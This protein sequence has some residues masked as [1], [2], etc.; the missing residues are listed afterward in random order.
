M[1]A[2]VVLVAPCKAGSAAG[3]G[4]AQPPAH[5]SPAMSPQLAQEWGF[6][7]PHSPEVRQCRGPCLPPAL[8]PPLSNAPDKGPGA[9]GQPWP[10]APNDVGCM[11]AAQQTPSMGQEPCGCVQ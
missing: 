9:W 4:A 11:G 1:A 6:P 3:R 10:L 7:R 8:R 5:A 2:T